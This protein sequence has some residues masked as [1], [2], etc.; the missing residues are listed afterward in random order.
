MSIQRQLRDIQARAEQ[1]INGSPSLED[2]EEFS[3]YNEELRNYL[4]IHLV[5]VELRQRVYEIPEI[6]K[7]STTQIASRGLFTAF[8][9]F[10]TSP[11]ITY[12]SNRQQIENAMQLVSEARGKYATI[13]LLARNA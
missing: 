6:L 4:L 7:E 5:D 3:Q 10:F 8:L 12:F 11:F 9:T 2:I 1:L 13:E